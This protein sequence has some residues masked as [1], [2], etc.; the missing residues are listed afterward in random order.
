MD[1]VKP[2]C[3]YYIKLGDMANKENLL[4]LQMQLDG[5]RNLIIKF[6]MHLVK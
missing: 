5:H 4:N 6:I 1:G 2:L 3:I